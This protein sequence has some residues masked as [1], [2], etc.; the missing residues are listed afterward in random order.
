MS[1]ACWGLVLLAAV[2]QPPPAQAQ[3][4]EAIDPSP[5][6]EAAPADLSRLDEQALRDL[7]GS[8]GHP[9]AEL[10]RARAELLR[11][12]PSDA[13]RAFAMNGEAWALADAFEGEASYDL[14]TRVRA[15]YAGH[16]DPALEREVARAIQGQANALDVIDAAREVASGAP[17]QAVT[18]ETIDLDSPSYR[19]RRELVDVY[20]DRREPAIRAIVLQERYNLAMGELIAGT[21][22]LEA[23]RTLIGE[24][25][26][27]DGIEAQRQIAEILTSIAF[28]VHHEPRRQIEVWNEIIRRFADSR[29]RLLW[30]KVDDAFANAAWAYERLGDAD[31]ERRM[32][33]AQM[34]WW[35]RNDRTER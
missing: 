15:R 29:D 10:E 30:S 23:L 7:A 16:A 27:L 32:R 3:L 34:D 9:P 12:F 26:Q 18:H 35:E 20:G 1:R 13:N 31:G 25:E 2:A 21:G 28:F 19:L 8:R 33:E 4:I 22:R 6:S 24:Y 11:R 14:F 5:A 17:L